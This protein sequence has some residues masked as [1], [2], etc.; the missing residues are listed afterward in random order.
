M[1]AGCLEA[2]ILLTILLTN[3]LSLNGTV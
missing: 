1:L 2:S 3:D